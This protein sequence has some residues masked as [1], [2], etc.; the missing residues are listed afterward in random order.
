MIYWPDPCTAPGRPAN[1]YLE[2]T[3]SKVYP[4]VSQDA[5]GCAA[6]QQFSTPGGVPSHV[7]VPTPG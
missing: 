7:S 6:L 4:D 2:G 3:Y 1:V 5:R